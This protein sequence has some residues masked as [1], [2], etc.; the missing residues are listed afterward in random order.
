MKIKD[1]KVLKLSILITVKT[2]FIFVCLCL[3]IGFDWIR[4]KIEEDVLHMHEKD[5]CQ[6][7]HHV[8]PSGQ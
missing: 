2:F 5:G 3:A 1:N 8:T 4:F 6:Q 7:H